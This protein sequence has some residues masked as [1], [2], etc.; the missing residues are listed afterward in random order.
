MRFFL[1]LLFFSVGMYSRGGGRCVGFSVKSN[2]KR[3]SIFWMIFRKCMEKISEQG[4]KNNGNIV[5]EL[6]K[7]CEI[8]LCP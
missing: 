3:F 8:V 1:L 5:H 7:E 4:N 6:L 2:W